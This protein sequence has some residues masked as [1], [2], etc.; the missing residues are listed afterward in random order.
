MK[1]ILSLFFVIIFT[2]VSFVGCNNTD[3][4]KT[5]YRHGL[6]VIS[7]MHEMSRSEEYLECLAA[8]DDDVKN[9]ISQISSGDYTKPQKV[10]KITF[11]DGILSQ[12]FESE[13]INADGLSLTLKEYLELKM[14]SAYASNL[15]ARSG[16][17][18]L[19]ATSLCA[20][21]KTFLCNELDETVVYLYTFKNA[22]PAMVSFVP[23]EDGAVLATGYFILIDYLST[24]T[25]EDVE[26]L[27]FGV[28]VDVE[29]LK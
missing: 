22:K 25:Q 10:Y 27:F 17:N 15:N 8:P 21:E 9:I 7:L 13:N 14:R 18:Y 4:S 11:S 12:V 1:R 24:N 5:L 26:K 19:V 2:C 6:D 16:S 20:A 28:D 23:G 3:G 29:V